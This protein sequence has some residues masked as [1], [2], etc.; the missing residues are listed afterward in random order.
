MFK[1][2]QFVYVAVP[3]GQR[4][5]EGDSLIWQT[6]KNSVPDFAVNTVGGPLMHAH[7]RRP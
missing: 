7:E 6:R 1:L 5:S 3:G 2:S 4:S